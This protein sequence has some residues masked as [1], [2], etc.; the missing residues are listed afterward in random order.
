MRVLL[1]LFL[2]FFKLGAFTF[3]GGYA[4]ISLI[5]NEVV[6][7][8]GWLTRDEM[9]DIITIAE[10]TPGP[11]AINMATF[12]GAKTKG[13]LGAIV[14]TLGL[15]IPPLV[16][17]SVIA[18]VLEQF[19][20][21]AVI[22]YALRGI[23]A[24]VVVLILNA[25]LKFF[26]GM[27]KSVMSYIFLATAFLIS[28][29]TDF[30]VVYIIL[31]GAVVGVSITFIRSYLIKKKTKNIT[32]TSPENSGEKATISELAGGIVPDDTNIEGGED[33]SNDSVELPRT[34]HDNG[35]YSGDNVAINV[36]SDGDII[37]DK[38][39]S[40]D[41]NVNNVEDAPTT[42]IQF[43]QSN[44]NIDTSNTNNSNTC[45]GVSSGDTLEE[46]GKI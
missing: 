17:I 41:I 19:K 9:L 43:A 45:I 4:M 7:K 44:E 15:I 33:T 18:L 34:H 6:T 20:E 29:L 10:S 1:G 42:A 24:G 3:G 25:F 26:K 2:T 14:A 35:E 32:E 5:E 40:D 11:I 30:G 8:R 39:H 22:A 23:Q 13:I 27:D 28:L 36:A 46:E 31:I 37:G 16:I 38:A 12:V 21:I